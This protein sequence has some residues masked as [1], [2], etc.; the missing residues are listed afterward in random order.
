MDELIREILN[1]P[2]ADNVIA[3]ATVATV[4][5]AIFA[6]IA[7]WLL[8]KKSRLQQ[9]AADS[10]AGF[11]ML[12]Q[13][14]KDVPS[15]LRFHGITNDELN[16]ANIKPEE[17]SYFLSNMTTGGIYYRTIDKAH[18]ISLKELQ[19]K[20]ANPGCNNNLLQRLKERLFKRRGIIQFFQND[21]YYGMM[22]R[23]QSTRDAWAICSCCLAPS[24]YKSQL[25]FLS[26]ENGGPS[27]ELKDYLISHHKH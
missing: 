23:Q 17:L 15:V 27:K 2:T 18:K 24:D 14:I 7:S 8:Q 9:S 11:A 21:G 10:L 25:D 13:T 20:A 26:D 19:K 1:K 6:T 4:I 3:I 22:F 16:I 5:A 12:E